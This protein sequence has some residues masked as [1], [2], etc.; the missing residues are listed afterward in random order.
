MRK[1]QLIFLH[2]RNG[3]QKIWTA[4]WEWSTFLQI[5]TNYIC[6]SNCKTNK[7]IC[8]IHKINKLPKKKK[9][10]A[11]L[12]L[13]IL[14]TANTPIQEMIFMTEGTLNQNKI[15]KRIEET[16][17]GQALPLPLVPTIATLF[18]AGTTNDIPSRIF[19]SGK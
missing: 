6:S 12:D 14:L 15:S 19:L 16:W 8:C 4:I 5:D 18:P 10:Y 2:F 9:T 13:L 3:C 11:W 17:Q 1:P 7:H